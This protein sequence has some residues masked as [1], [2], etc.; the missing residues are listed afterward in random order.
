MASAPDVLFKGI[1]RG[2]TRGYTAKVLQAFRPE[3]VVI[4]C[5]GS[6]SLAAV[7][8]EAGVLPHDIVCGDVS[9]YSTALGNAIMGQDWR[10]EVKPDCPFPE[11]AE[12]LNAALAESSDPIAKAAVALFGV[13]YLQ[14]VKKKANRFY[15][16]LQAELCR[17]APSYLEQL[18]LQALGLAEGLSGCQY[19][20]RDMW[21]T[22]D[23]YMPK[24]EVDKIYLAQREVYDAWREA[25]QRVREDMEIVSIPT[26]VAEMARLAVQALDAMTEDGAAD[27]AADGS[28][29]EP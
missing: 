26:A 15:E 23:E 3:I 11:L 8:K 6:F 27:G 13:R 24:A 7:A 14:Y 18:R 16:N 22:L 29:Q 5:C 1:P 17:N 19:H 20:A 4:P 12:I 21:L 28:E 2:P 25:L 10:L 9:L